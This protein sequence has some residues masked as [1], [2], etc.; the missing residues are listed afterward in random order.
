V[1]RTSAAASEGARAAHRGA[2]FAARWVRPGTEVVLLF[3]LALGVRLLAW[4]LRPAILA[5]SLGLLRAGEDLATNGLP[6]LFRT[7]HHPFPVLLVA[8][9]PRWA[10][11]ERWASIGAAVCGA[12]AVFPVHVVARSAAGRHAATVAVLLYAVLPKFVSI[13]SV[14]M[15]EAALL[16]LFAGALSLAFS[17]VTARTPRTRLLR[18]ALAGVCAGFAY[19]SRP[20]GL[21]AGILAVAA[22]VIRGRTG[23]RGR[24]AFL[25][26]CAFLFV[27]LPWV[28][29]L[30]DHGGE[31][32]LSPKKDL[33]A[34]VGLED[35]PREAANEADAAERVRN[36]ASALWGAMGP[37]LVLVLAGVLPWRRWRRHRSARTRWLLLAG[38]GFLCAVLLRLSWGWDYA[39]G[40][41][42]LA[43]AT[44][45]LP[46]AGEG[47]YV[48]VTFLSRAVRRRRAALFLTM[49]LAVPLGVLAILRP[50]GESGGRARILGE[51]IAAAER[52]RRGTGDVVIATFKEPLVAYYADRALREAGLPRRAR[53]LPLF[54]RHRSL[55]E[56]SA[57]AEGRRAALRET[58]SQGGAGWIVLSFWDRV[59]DQGGTRSPGEDLARLLAEDGVVG[60]PVIGS[61]ELVAFPLT[62]R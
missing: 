3:L 39:A 41:Q 60:K 34:F 19:L 49:L 10:D 7:T 47:L 8:A 62:R 21:V 48:L 38:A 36:L 14:P 46:F 43:A 17:S 51:Q 16:P 27:A 13:A 54:R 31:L 58:L 22:L 1:T 30:S 45:L 11:A 29:A 35:A 26:T 32:E 53:D 33:S 44:L 55:L 37:A 57:D 9:I 61:S 24:S 18:A 4:A 42:A 25:A 59:S 12:V 15:A 2:R 5:D 52:E 23:E 20:E 6:A 50:D 40:R 28:A 56:V